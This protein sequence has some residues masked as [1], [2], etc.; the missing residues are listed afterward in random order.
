MPAVLAH[1]A[2]MMLARDRV[3][4]IRNRLLWRKS[5]GAPL[6]DLELRILRLASLTWTLMTESAEERRDLELPSADWPDGIGSNVSRFCVM[7]CMGPDI[8]GLSAIVA[9]AQAVWFDTIHKGTPDSSREQVNARSHDFAMEI[10][11]RAA[12]AFTERPST[13]PNWA[14]EYLRDLNYVRAYV[15]GHLTHL[16]GDMIAH[17]FINDVEWHVPARQPPGLFSFETFK[18]GHDKVEGSLDTRVAIE[19]FKRSGPRSGQPWSAF[20]PTIDEVPPELFVGYEKAVIE[21][22]GATPDTR[23]KGLAGFENAIELPPTPDTD[24]FRDG[25]N[26]LT[27]GGVGIMYN[28]GYASW[29]G[30]LSLGLVPILATFPLAFALPNGNDWFEKSS[31]DAGERAAFEAL[32]LPLALNSL[33]PVIYGAVAASIT[34]RGAEAILTAGLLG[35]SVTALFS[36][37]YFIT[38]A[39]PDPGAEFRWILM[40]ALPAATG[41]ALTI[42]SLAAGGRRS[43]LLLLFA[44]PFIVFVAAALLLALFSELIGNESETAGTVSWAILSGLIVVVGLILLFVW[45]PFKA[46]DFRI[47]EEAFAFPAMRPHHV[48][49]FDRSSLFD[50]PNQKDA[51]LRELHYP[52]GARVLLKLWWTGTGDFFIRPRHTHIEFV[53]A[54]DGS[55]PGI[56]PAPITPMTQQQLAAFLMTAVPGLQAELVHA[57]DANVEVPPGAVFADHGDVRESGANDTPEFELTEAAAEFKQLGTENNDGAYKLFHAP[58]RM[59]SVRFDRFGPVPFQ[60]RETE[61]M[62]GK[63][64]IS[65][66]GTSISGIDT[67]FRFFFQP[68]DRIVFNGQAR[69]VTLVN[70][71]LS[72][73]ISSPFRPAPDRSEYSRLGTTFE[74]QRGYSFVAQP[75]PR[76][77]FGDTI[78]D[79]AGD[80]GALFCMAGTSRML[81][82]TEARISEFDT[83]TGPGGAAIP[84]PDLGPVAQVF[85]NWS[86]DRRLVEEWREAVIGGATIDTTPPATVG[87]RILAQQGWIPTLRKWLRMVDDPAHSMIDPAHRN[88]GANEPTNQELSLAM[89]KL[90]SMSEPIALT[91]RP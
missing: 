25:F 14:R 63:G 67:D 27:K 12:F 39:T 80:L 8:P 85:R 76:S 84:F 46:R 37:I 64:N 54:R 83:F 59:Q 86:L 73:V 68:G 91:P 89:A 48:R 65:G 23:P 52:T 81:D 61:A 15:L 31:A 10:Y 4:D 6:T 1:T 19:F 51:T 5:L 30:F 88:G 18:F 33:L 28:W 40:F 71:D 87:D 55:A 90:L 57:G 42:S 58:K 13:G 2:I 69:I 21:I 62:P 66:S 74:A 79:I 78:M 77:G 43:K 9:P 26:T 47:P 38:L 20:W 32:T 70:N 75:R 56:I 11:R 45:L 22:Y 41:L 53:F 72:L 17:P 16:A 49:L 82:G 3:E 24:F 34:W 50:L 35:S 60:E 36:L 29:L 7:G 44:A